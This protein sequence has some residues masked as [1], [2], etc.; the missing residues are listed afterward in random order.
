MELSFSFLAPTSQMSQLYFSFFFSTLRVF[1]PWTILSN[2]S[3]FLFLRRLLALELGKFQLQYC[4]K[5]DHFGLQIQVDS[6]VVMCGWG[7][8]LAK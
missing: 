4:K 8:Y 1:K 2:E 7:Y 5:S 6:Y 3:N